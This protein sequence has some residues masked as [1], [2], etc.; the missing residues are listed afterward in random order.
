[1]TT[2]NYIVLFGTVIFLIPFGKRGHSFARSAGS[3]HPVII[4]LA[5]AI[6]LQ[7]LSQVFHTIHLS[8]YAVAGAGEIV[9]DGCAEVLFMLS[10]V[11]QTTLLIAI[12]MGYTLLPTRQNSM[13]VIQAIAVLSLV[14]H[15]VL[16]SFGEMQ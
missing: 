7:I 13:I 1:M 12:A 16:V 8:W 6:A 15:L 2:L 14:I 9:L 10:Q 4:L 5:G 3:I 11:L